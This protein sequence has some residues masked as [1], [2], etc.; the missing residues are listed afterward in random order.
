MRAALI[1]S[2]RLAMHRLVVAVAL[3]AV[4]AGRAPAAETHPFSVHDMQAMQRISEPSVSPDGRLVAFTVQ[5]TDLDAN[6]RRADLWLADV[7]GTW[8]RPLT[9]DP[10]NDTGARWDPDGRTLYFLST[11]SGSQQV[12]RLHV[13]GGEAERVTDLPL[14]VEN[15]RLTPDGKRLVVSMAVFPGSTPAETRARLD[16]RAAA[17]ASGRLY[18][19]LFIRH[20]DTWNDGT[21]NHLF[22]YPLP[23]GPALDLMPQMDADAPSKPFGGI[24]EFAIAPDGRSVVFAAK[25][26]G[27]EEAWSTNFDLFEAPLAGGVAPR[28]LTT[29]PASDTQPRFSPDGKHLAWMAMSRAGYEADAY[30]FVV[31]EAAS[32]RERT[33]ELRA[34]TGPT[35]DRSPETFVWSSD[36]RELYASGDHLGQAALFALE[37]A[38]GKCRIVVGAGSTTAPQALPGARL[39][40][41]MH[42]LL[43]PTE[44]YTVAARGGTPR[45]VTRLNAERVAAARFGAPE[46]FW[47]EGAHGDRVHGFLVRPVDFD[48]ARRYPV[49]YVIHGGPQG[50]FGNQ[51]HY[52]WNPQT[53]A[54]AGYAVLLV[55]FHGSTGYGQA[56][57]DAIRGDYGGGPY[58]DLMK[59]LDFALGR[60]P[61]LDGERVAALGA[62]FGGYMINWIAGQTDRFRCLVS[63]DGNLDERM[64]YFDTEELWFP[65]W[66]QQGTPWENP[67]GYA[68]HNPVEHVQNW[69]TPMLVIHGGKDYRVVETQGFGVFNALQRRGI[70]SK[71][72]YFP[73]ENHWVLKPHN[74]ILW[75]DTV[76]AWL[77]QWLRDGAGSRGGASGTAR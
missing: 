1:T 60:Y 8:A 53:Y 57:C 23:A 29:N 71:F 3:G 11:R 72:L 66:D 14:D 2:G 35:D 28:R 17:K 49:A 43:A 77:D 33:L 42:S 22:V 70:P 6:K 27:R 32:G 55:N 62:S 39:L 37:V 47:F 21:R 25:D 20:W 64:S 58:E 56:F 5:S 46:E 36:G 59:G 19:R 61:F 51:F 63:H 69:R 18:D 31:R 40:F 50:A 16:E 74:S 24:E 7:Q 9:R 26:V 15:L 12:W 65:E 52:R 68:R 4:F 10:A 54:G 13:D 73:D 41:A 75:H 76:L 38:T 45:P 44:L 67:P 30:R 48:P 34:G